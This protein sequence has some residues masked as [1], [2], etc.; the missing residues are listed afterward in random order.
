MKT[1][2]KKNKQY[3]LLIIGGGA[4]GILAALAAVE[5]KITVA[6]LEKEEKLGK[7]IL[8][9]GGGRCNL[10]NTGDL[11]DFIKNIPGNGKFLYSA[12]HNF[13][14]P[15]LLNLLHKLGLETKVEE[16]GKI[17]PVSDKAQTVVE[18]LQKAL[19]EKGVDIFY[20]SPVQKLLI[21]EGKCC[22]VQLLTGKEMLSQCTILATGGLSFPATGSTGDGYRIAEEI[23]H[24]LTDFFPAAVAL[25]CN[26]PYIEDK[27]LQGLSWTEIV[28][29]V[30]KGKKKIAAEKG[31]LIFTHFG[32]S[33]PAALRVS[34]Y[35]ALAQKKDSAPLQG[36]IDLFP[37]KKITLI[38][39]ELKNLIVKQSK[40]S[41]KNILQ[42]YLPE[43]LALV[44]LKQTKID[45]EKQASQLSNAELEKIASFLKAVPIIIQTTRSLKE[46]TVTGGG[47]KIKEIN[48]QTMS[49]R[50]IENLYFAG[51]IVDIDAQT[52][53]Y[54]L[55]CAFSMGYLAGQESARKMKADT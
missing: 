29:T 46:A 50:L 22:G 15:D 41:V 13:F 33:G 55:Q 35:V 43:R 49:S 18:I 40:K 51:E 26:A 45:A 4:A 7:K 42:D 30:Y 24:S 10:T 19:Q 27:S 3:D 37:V 8:L 6:I 2:N 34:R 17:Y 54:N 16:K 53:G 32:L 39:E 44:C 1:K 21:K 28:L 31:D 14:Q 9:T 20:N 48:P 5:E 25:V 36:E 47:V 38:Q 52:G 12:F 23:G 11:E